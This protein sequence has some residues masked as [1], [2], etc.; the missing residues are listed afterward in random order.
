MNELNRIKEQNFVWTQNSLQSELIEWHKKK[1][2]EPSW[3]LRC[4]SLSL[5]QVQHSLIIA[6]FV[7]IISYVWI[8]DASGAVHAQPMQHC[9]LLIKNWSTSSWM[10]TTD[11]GI[12]W[13]VEV[14]QVCHQPPTCENW[15]VLWIITIISLSWLSIIH[16]MI[17]LEPWNGLHRRVQCQAMW[18]ES[19]FLPQHSRWTIFW[20]KSLLGR[21]PRNCWHQIAHQRFS[22][23]VVLGSS[24]CCC[25]R[26]QQFW[27]SNWLVQNRTLLTTCMGN[28]SINWMCSLNLFGK[29]MEQ[30]FDCLQLWA[31][32]LDGWGYL[33]GWTSCVKLQ[34]QRQRFYFT[35]HLVKMKKKESMY[36]AFLLSLPIKL[37]LSYL[38]KV[39][40]LQR[41][42][43]QQK[44]KINS[45]A[46]SIRDNY[47]F[48]IVGSPKHTEELW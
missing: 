39:L 44:N 46:K 25:S 2:W 35:L 27:L 43:F 40:I 28:E 7:P 22:W 1:L 21:I 24:T 23:N 10:S 45:K 16:L 36:S 5:A 38:I 47:I 30:C 15:W 3:F 9:L 42:A 20:S 8:Q 48:S 29:S 17:D 13:R 6:Q 37:T 18:N 31:R 26:Y 34:N 33:S 41:Q 19:R 32:Q 12:Y 4:L 14:F 11:S